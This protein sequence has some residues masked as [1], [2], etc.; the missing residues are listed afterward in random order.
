[1]DK[2]LMEMCCKRLIKTYTQIMLAVLNNIPN[3]IRKARLRLHKV[4]GKEDMPF[5]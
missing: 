1:M 2:T 3:E 5:F 4:E